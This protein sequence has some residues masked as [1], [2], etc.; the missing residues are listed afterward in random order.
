MKVLAF[1][2]MHEKI[3]IKYCTANW[4]RF[5]CLLQFLLYNVYRIIVVIVT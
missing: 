2:A 1:I 4:H 5:Q 3:Q